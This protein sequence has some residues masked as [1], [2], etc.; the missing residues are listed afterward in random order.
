MNISN[1]NLNFAGR[2]YLKNPRLWTPKMKNAIA[3]NQS[4]QEALKSKDVIG[5]IATK[6]E[7]KS[8]DFNARHTI[9]DTLYKVSFDVQDESTSILNKILDKIYPAK[10]YPINRHFH[11]E[12]TTVKRIEKLK[13]HNT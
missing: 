7:K 10:T 6:I 13:I 3:N 2:L 1:T 11:S 5:N 8:P 4:I 9:G 12:E